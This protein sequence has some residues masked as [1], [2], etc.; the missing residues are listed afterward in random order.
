MAI[1]NLGD[2]MIFTRIFKWTSDGSGD[3]SEEFLRLANTKLLSIQLAPGNSGD[4]TTNVPTN[5]YGVVIN[6]SYGEDITEGEFASNSNSVAES[7][8]ANPAI[9]MTTTWTVVVSGAGSANEGIVR[10]EMETLG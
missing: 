8:Y 3:A 6:D 2:N 5:E 10:M 7:L 1:P 4:L 9:P